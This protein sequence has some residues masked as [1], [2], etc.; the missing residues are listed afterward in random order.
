MARSRTSLESQR[1]LPLWTNIRA[2]MGHQSY[3]AQAWPQ[4]PTTPAVWSSFLALN[5]QS[6][7]PQPVSSI[8]AKQ[9]L[10]GPHCS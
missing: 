5:L 1:Q 7:H 9:L 3:A 8:K 10:L 4:C 2:R 6:I